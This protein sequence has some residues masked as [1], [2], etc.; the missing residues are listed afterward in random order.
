MKESHK[1][2]LQIV[3]QFLGKYPDQRFGQALY[4]LGIN[5]F[6]DKVNPE[7]KEHLLK[8]IYSDSDRDILKRIIVAKN[9]IGF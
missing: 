9:E 7:I 4:N 8:D 6:A 2:I 1:V 5:E 3:G